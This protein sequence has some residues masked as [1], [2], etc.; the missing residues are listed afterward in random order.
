M[1]FK[2]RE[3]MKLKWLGTAGFEIKINDQIFL[4]DPYLSRNKNSNPVQ[5]LQPYDIKKADQIFI[6]HGHFDHVMDV[7]SI[8]GLTNAQVYCSESTARSLMQ[9]SESA[10][11]LLTKEQFVPISKEKTI[12]EFK[13]YSAQPFFS[14]HV[15]FDKKLIIST[16]LKIN[17]RFFKYLP[18]NKNFPCGQVLSW[19]FFINGKVVQFFGSAGAS[20][21]E[22]KTL[23]DPPVDILL[24]PLQGHTHICDI[25]LEYVR[26]LKPEIVIP[27]HFDN[28]FP[29]I[30][31]FVDINPFVKNVQKNYKETTLIVPEINKTISL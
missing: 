5:N 15:S 16:L 10:T 31:K 13:G 26:I 20:V 23:C 18:L 17:L 27:H 30:S 19:R 9:N 24:V 2:K 14:N 8:A 11:T 4:L 12:F 21:Q 3:S 28:F 25:G 29:P 6:S 22:L 1:V 7:P